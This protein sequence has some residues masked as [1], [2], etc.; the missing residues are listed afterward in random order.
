[1][2]VPLPRRPSTAG[3][4]TLALC[5]V[6]AGGPPA[7][8]AGTAGPA[9]RW[10]G[11]TLAGRFTQG[12][13]TFPF[14]ASRGAGPAAAAA[15][16][17]EGFDAFVE[18]AMKEFEVPGLA[19]AVVMDGKVVHAKGYGLRDVAHDLPVTT[20]TLFAIG[21]STKA[22]TTFVMAT[23]VDEGRLE[24]DR[25]VVD[26]IPGFRM[27]DEV[28]TR[29]L[30]PRD[31]VTHRSGLP[32]HDLVWY[33]N[34]GATRKELVERLAHLAPYR[35][36]RAEFHYQNL[37]Y[38]T[39]GHLVEVL[40]GKSWEEAVRERILDPLGMTA[41]NFSVLDSQRAEDFARGHERRDEQVREVPFREITNMGPA[42]SINSNVEEMAR[43]LLVH[44]GGG[45]FGGRTLLSRPTLDDLQA[46]HM[47]LAVPPEKPETPQR[48]YALGWFVEP[49]RGHNRLHHGGNIDGFS[50]MVSF[51]PQDGIGMV[52]LANMGGTPLPELLMRHAMDRL[53]D[54]PAKDWAGEALGKREKALAAEKEAK[55]KKEIARVA[56]TKPAHPLAE[57][58]GEYAN[59]GYGPLKVALENGRLIAEYNGIE[60]PLEHWHFEVFSGAKGGK[61]PDLEDV[62]LMFLTNW[63]G[64]VDAVAAPSEP[65]VEEIVFKRRPDTRMSD[66]AFLRQ[67]LG[68][69]ELAG[70]TLTVEIKGSVLIAV[71]PGQPAYELVPGRLHEFT[72]R[73][74]ST[75]SL[76]FVVDPEEGATEIQ[77]SQ[78]EGVYTARRAK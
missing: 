6:L 59:P 61:D 10:E 66:P 74:F 70:E 3:T 45:R 44:L 28:A 29:R 16:R 67:Y 38:L 60:A 8:A 76:R 34:A 53:L 69:Y 24:W 72:L 5:L 78:P 7:P 23:L 47:A 64:E 19:L 62:K 68:T 50:A 43:W 20:R 65:E 51:L 14:S 37:M 48:S 58:A 9:G 56:G 26:Y 54:L 40:T 17:L 21:S 12:G 63:R 27:Q 2:R 36:L 30:T 39:A 57:Y 13:Q 49:Y 11:A 71:L 1:M 15:A 35:D 18:T 32:R 73:R 46:P 4:F 31:L 55:A 22:F 75:I 42:G 77:V 52:A 33:N 41:S 25:P